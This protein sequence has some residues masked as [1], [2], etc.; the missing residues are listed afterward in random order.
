LVGDDEAGAS[1]DTRDATG[2]ADGPE[3]TCVDEVVAVSEV[4]RP[5]IPPPAP[6][7][8]MALAG[9]RADFPPP[10]LARNTVTAM[11]K[12]PAAAHA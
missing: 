8:T 6:A 7:A 2:E 1:V 5:A 4:G 12:P 11:A 10:E 9:L 3:T